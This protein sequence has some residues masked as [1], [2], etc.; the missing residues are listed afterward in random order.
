MKRKILL[1]HPTVGGGSLITSL[2]IAETLV[3]MDY[4]I[5]VVDPWEYRFLIRKKF[6]DQNKK[7]INCLTKEVTYEYLFKA[8][9]DFK[10]D[11]FLTIFG[12]YIRKDLFSFMKREKV[13]SCCWFLDD[14]WGFDEAAE[15]ASNYDYFFTHEPT[16]VERYRK[17]GVKKVEYLPEA[18]NPNVHKK[19]KLDENE[20]SK[21]KC[22]LSFVG[23]PHPN[24]IGFL[25][26]LAD[27]DLKVWGDGWEEINPR[28]KGCIQ[29]GDVP[30]N[31]MVKIFNA[32]KI[33]L[34]LHPT[35]GMKKEILGDG[36]NPRTFAIA[37]CGA[38][39][40]V[41]ERGEMKKFFKIGEEVV[42]F[43][44]ID[45]L[46]DLVEY[47]LA[48]SDEREVIATRAQKRAYK[49]HTY[50]HRLEKMFNFIE[51]NEYLDFSP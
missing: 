9:R 17:L 45:E 5:K 6:P 16:T 25:E 51:Q 40:L 8:I 30:Q 31:V 23:K 27:Y 3:E 44:H 24:R 46:P 22:D 26:K 15:V 49:E 38:F 35:Y 20:L 47:Y 10:P 37:G 36:I 39:Q 21:Y 32:S 11:L 28:L 19:M 18:C 29:G 43:K 34:N 14:P 33:V 7:D 13:I 4:P 12:V 1:A 48:H 42:T 2:N 41:D 50:R